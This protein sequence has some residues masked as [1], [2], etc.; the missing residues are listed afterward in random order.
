MLYK[1][2]IQQSILLN[3]LLILFKVLSTV[4]IVADLLTLDTEAATL[5]LLIITLSTSNLLKDYLNLI[6]F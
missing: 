5:N 1:F 3:Q 2:L 6:I 4:Y